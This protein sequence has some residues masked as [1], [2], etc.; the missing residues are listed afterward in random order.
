MNKME[1]LMK[2]LLL[3]TF[4][5]SLSAAASD[6]CVTVERVLINNE[7]KGAKDCITQPEPCKPG[8]VFGYCPT[9]IYY[10]V[11][12]IEEM[13]TIRD[14]CENKILRQGS[15]KRKEKIQQ[16]IKSD[17]PEYRERDAIEVGRNT[18]REI[19]RRR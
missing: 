9:I 1:I 7:F 6:Q 2:N 14:N 3:L 4:L 8:Y 16:I 10:N 17:T 11:Y 18:C 12:S 5:L 15:E 19:S 13:V